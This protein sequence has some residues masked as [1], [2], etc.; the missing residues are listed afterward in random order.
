MAI[1]RT[2]KSIRVKQVDAAAIIE[3]C[4][5]HKLDRVSAGIDVSK[6]DLFV[7][8]R[9]S[10]Q[11]FS[12][13]IK[14]LQ[15]AEIGLFVGLLSEINEQIQVQVGLESTGTYGDVIRFALHTAGFDV[16]RISG[17][18]VSDYEEIFDGVPSKH[19]GKDAAMIAELL[20]FGKATAW[21]WKGDDEN[22]RRMAQ[23]VDRL[24]IHTSLETMWTGRLEALLARHWPELTTFLQL[25]SA[26]LI[27]A[28]QHYVTPQAMSDD[29]NAAARLQAWG[30]GPLKRE[31]IDRIVASAASSVGVP[32]TA[33]EQA[34]LKEICGHILEA[35]RVQ[36]AS[37]RELKELSSANEI[38]GRMKVALGE[39]TA[40]VLWVLLGD[41]RNYPCAGAYVKA[42]GLNLKVRSSGTQKGQLRITRRGPARVRRWMYFAALRAVQQ[43]AV[44]KWFDAKKAKNER[45]GAM[46]ATVAVMRKLLRAVWHTS[47][48]GDEF[49]WGLLFPGRPIHSPRKEKTE[50]ATTT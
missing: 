31:K 17:K 43:P 33:A 20:D 45:A 49:K 50:M 2:Y 12:Q 9:F 26:T 6:H 4:R 41:P 35:R 48:T 1:R 3:H 44:T 19:D 22:D 37:R 47:T 25:T 46:L 18:A 21:P 5:R 24:D 29:E 36:K 23:A 40:C 13:P 32:M 10:G 14:V 39:A 15:P 30:R 28:V 42:A 11:H 16:F 34:W 8:F 27:S 7:V 38:I